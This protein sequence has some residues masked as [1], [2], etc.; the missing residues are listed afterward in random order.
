MHLLGIKYI[1]IFDD[2]LHSSDVIYSITDRFL[3]VSPLNYYYFFKYKI[4]AEAFDTVDS[5]H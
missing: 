2:F 4:L 5:L 3:L 1:L